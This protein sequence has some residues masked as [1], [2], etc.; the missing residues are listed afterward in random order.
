MTERP[1]AELGPARFIVI[2]VGVG[3]PDEPQLREASVRPGARFVVG[4]LAVH[5]RGKLRGF[6]AARSLGLPSTAESDSA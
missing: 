3:Q 6:P 4:M 1:I 2:D 5:V